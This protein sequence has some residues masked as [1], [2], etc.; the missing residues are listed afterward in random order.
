MRRK[1][2]RT[3]MKEKAST[4]KT[5]RRQFLQFQRRLYP[6]RSFLFFFLS[7]LSSFLSFSF[8]FFSLK[9]LTIFIAQFIEK[10]LD[11]DE[12]NFWIEFLKDP[13]GGKRKD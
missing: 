3:S 10:D 13:D 7:F 1:M 6:E 5:Q 9:K 8:F 4:P 12:L 11:K 2:M